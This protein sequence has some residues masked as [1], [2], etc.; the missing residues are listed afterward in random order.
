MGTIAPSSARAELFCRMMNC[1]GHMKLN[2]TQ[3]LDVIEGAILQRKLHT[4]LTIEEMRKVLADI[5]MGE[6]EA[7]AS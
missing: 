1:F 4:Q 2:L 7:N 6:P 3:Q 5:G